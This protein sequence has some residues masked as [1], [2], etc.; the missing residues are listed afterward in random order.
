VHPVGF[1]TRIFYCYNIYL[2][3]GSR[4]T[5]R[6]VACVK[7]IY[8][9]VKVK[10]SHYR[11]MGPRGLWDVKVSRFRDIGIGDRLSAIRTGCLY[12]KSILSLIFRGWVDPRH[13]ELSG[14][15]EN[16]PV[17]PPGIEHLPQDNRFRT[18]LICC[19]FWK[20]LGRIW[21]TCGCEYEPCRLLCSALHCARG[22]SPSFLYV[23][24]N[25]PTEKLTMW[26]LHNVE[27]DDP[28]SMGSAGHMRYSLGWREQDVGDFVCVCRLEDSVEWRQ[29]NTGD[30]RNWVSG[31]G[32]KMVTGSLL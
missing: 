16:K 23:D 21:G 15:T 18:L 26:I 11:P 6:N 25:F 32:V 20:S 24:Y 5:S 7:H 17:T 14:A 1:I 3:D 27:P 19:K 2:K 22:H 9:N 31:M 28:P 30:M 12:P 4:V 13:M 8:D 29:M 10:W